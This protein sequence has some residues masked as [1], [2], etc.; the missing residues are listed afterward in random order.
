MGNE[1]SSFSVSMSAKK[2]GRNCP[3]YLHKA[4]SLTVFFLL[5]FL[6]AILCIVYRFLDRFIEG[7]SSSCYCGNKNSRNSSLKE[8]SESLYDRRNIFSKMYLF[9]IL[10]KWIDSNNNIDHSV[11]K[12]VRN[13]WSDCNCESCISWIKH[14]SDKLHVVISQPSGSNTKKPIENV[15]FIHGLFSSS[16][17]WTKSVFPNLS[18]T[19]KQSY[20]LFAVDLLGFGDSPKPMDCLYTLKDNLEMIENSVINPYELQSFHLVAHSMGCIIALA[21]ASKYSN[22]IKSVTLVAPACFPHYNK[23]G[24]DLEVLKRVAIQRIWP[25]AVFVGA[26]ASWY[27]HLSRSLHFIIL[28][29]HQ[30][31]EKLLKLLTNREP[32]NGMKDFTKHTHHS[33]WHT[34]HNVLYGGA[35]F[36]DEYL[37]I[38]KKSRAKISI[39]QGDRD[40]YVPIDCS[41]YIKQKIPRA[42]LNIV[43][44]ATH[45]SVIFQRKKEFIQNLERLWASSLAVKSFM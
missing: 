9:A 5:E 18:E 45:N 3:I 7:K 26:V 1:I 10:R 30:T 40:K 44:N 11:G 38:L 34:T 42:D 24:G 4:L 14:G 28:R 23:L 27:E 2:W 25:P 33:I 8:E 36:V 31:W 35:K 17:F 32:S 16:S 29:H 13:R 6:E 41:Y 43:P 15:I 19:T 39:V 37:E 22:T 21:L 20:R 12:C